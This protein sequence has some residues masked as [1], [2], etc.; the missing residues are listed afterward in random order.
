MLVNETEEVSQVAKTGEPTLL[1][2]EEHRKKADRVGGI[3]TATTTD[4]NKD[5]L[6]AETLGM[7]ADADE[8]A[9]AILGDAK[10]T[11]VS[12]NTDGQDQV[13]NEAVLGNANA[14]GA[15]DLLSVKEAEQVM[16]STENHVVS[17]DAESS[18]VRHPLTIL[19]LLRMQNS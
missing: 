2:A 13:T 17:L 15:V 1:G 3:N 9:D 16:L 14:K 18:S 5:A 19:E 8:S 10:P 11:N 7:A 12:T 6:P 4:A